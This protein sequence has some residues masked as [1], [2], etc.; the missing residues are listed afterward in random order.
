MKP[1]FPNTSLFVFLFE[2]FHE[3]GLEGVL[4]LP[5]VWSTSAGL[6]F[7]LWDSVEWS[8]TWLD[9]DNTNYCKFAIIKQEAIQIQWCT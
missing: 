8:E 9:T 7:L 4:L 1:K 2:G 5:F 6:A 3:D